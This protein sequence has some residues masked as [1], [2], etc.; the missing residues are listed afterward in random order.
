MALSTLQ[1]IADARDEMQAE[2][3]EAKPDQVYFD[4]GEQEE[5]P[6]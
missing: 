1:D 6:S 5:E 4:D 3:I 2:V